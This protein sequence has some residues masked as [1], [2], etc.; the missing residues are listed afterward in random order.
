MTQMATDNACLIQV[1]PERQ[2]FAV[3]FAYHALLFVAMRYARKRLTASAANLGPPLGKRRLS[4]DLEALGIGPWSRLEGSL[5]PRYQ[6][7]A[8]LQFSRDKLACGTCQGWTYFAIKHRTRRIAG[9]IYVRIVFNQ[10]SSGAGA[11]RFS[12]IA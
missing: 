7:A 6:M 11:M 12:R 4:R 8:T 3:R 5:R 1:C 9:G 10:D 2:P